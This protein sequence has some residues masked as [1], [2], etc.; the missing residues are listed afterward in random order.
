MFQKLSGCSYGLLFVY[1]LF[2]AKPHSAQGSELSCREVLQ[3][4]SSQI[5][6]EKSSKR[7]ATVQLT[8]TQLPNAKVRYGETVKVDGKKFETG[9]SIPVSDK[10]EYEEKALR[11]FFSRLYE[12]NLKSFNVEMAQVEKM[13][14]SA[15]GRFYIPLHFKMESKF[16]YLDRQESERRDRERQS[17]V[18]VANALKVFFDDQAPS[19]YSS[20]NF[21]ETNG[22]LF[23][24]IYQINPGNPTF[25]IDF[26]ANVFL[27]K[28]DRAGI[29][30]HRFP[31]VREVL[32][33]MP[34]EA[35]RAL[36]KELQLS[37][38][39]FNNFS[40][41]REAAIKAL[42]VEIAV[43]HGVPEKLSS[44][45]Q[46]SHQQSRKRINNQRTEKIKKKIRARLDEDIAR[47]T[48]FKNFEEYKAYILTIPEYRKFAE[49][50][51]Q[52]TTLTLVRHRGRR[53]SILKHGFKNVFETGTSSIS[54]GKEYAEG[55]VQVEAQGLLLTKDQYLQVIPPELRPKSTHVSHSSAKYFNES[56]YGT[57]HYL[58]PLEN[59]LRSDTPPVVT[60]TLGDSLDLSDRWNARPVLA[61]DFPY[62]AA[63]FIYDARV[64]L[65]DPE[66]LSSINYRAVDPFGQFRAVLPRFL[67][68]LN[69][70]IQVNIR[71][72][73]D[74]FGEPKGIPIVSTEAQIYGYVGIG[75]VK[76]L[77]ISK[78]DA[79]PESLK[80]VYGKLGIQLH[81]YKIRY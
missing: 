49:E 12:L 57:D 78:D 13:G 58:I 2:I 29:Q 19:M 71:K 14:I 53:A 34:M 28:L 35:I 38:S 67:G 80:S 36:L 54:N 32:I 6:I 10:K 9:A 33:D 44:D 41:W 79:L 47:H 65:N 23:F 60:F 70:M 4:I 63:P 8:S 52:T 76:G 15:D 1:S 3:R 75:D 26:N 59:L 66:F 39:I 43:L 7:F 40:R 27:G 37:E 64:K 21:E 5:E 20:I 11:I 81:Y 18:E 16:E 46:E 73:I 51:M 55:R 17:I 25:A 74:G 69:E 68:N 30:L 61:E 42:D 31:A 22:R 24:K 50:F 62:L 48:K 56:R 77:G 72:D 45:I